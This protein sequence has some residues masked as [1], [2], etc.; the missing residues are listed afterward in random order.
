MPAAARAIATRAERSASSTFARLPGQIE[1][2]PDDIPSKRSASSTVDPRIVQI[3]RRRA[4]RKVT[5]KMLCALAGVHEPN[6]YAMRRGEFV[7]KPATIERLE[8]AVEGQSRRM[9]SVN[10][11]ILAFVRVA[12]TVV[13]AEAARRELIAALTFERERHAPPATI[14]RARLRR[15][16]IYLAAVEL[17]VG[18]ADLARALKTTRQNVHQARRAIEELRERPAVDAL[19]EHCRALLKGEGT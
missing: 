2:W 4:E 15:V 16:A 5:H 1:I 6:W 11:V 13:A 10:S 9:A 7:P 12:E 17:E 18:N 19:L 8:R 3:D 14:A